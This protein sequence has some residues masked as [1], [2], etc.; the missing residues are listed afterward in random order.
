MAFAIAIKVN[1]NTYSVDVRRRHAAPLGV[2][3]RTWHDWH[4]G[5]HGRD[6]HIGDRSRHRQKPSSTQPV[7]ACARCRVDTT[8]LKQPV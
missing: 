7:S 8:A 6:R 2:A 5:R 4:K 3:R 1:G